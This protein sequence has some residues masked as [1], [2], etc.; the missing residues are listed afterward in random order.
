NHINE[1]RAL[2]PDKKLLRVVV[3]ATGDRLRAIIMT[4]ATTVAGLLPLAYGIGGN[5][6]YMGPMAMALGWGL[7][8]ATP[9]TLL[10][11]PSFYL[12]GDDISR[13]F[14][15]MAGLFR[16]KPEEPKTA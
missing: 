6:I 15:W 8:F 5:D 16:R 1:Q 12:V 10:L 11:V 2:S 4:T 7:L 3:E 14:G 9:L 13:L